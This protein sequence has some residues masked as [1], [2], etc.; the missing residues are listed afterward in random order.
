MLAAT[1][2]LVATLALLYLL[3]SVLFT[4][5]MSALIAYVLLPL[6]QLLV[7]WMPW[8]ESRPELS[9]SLAVTVIFVVA[10]GVT[11]GILAVVIPPTINQTEDFIDE[12]PTFFAAARETIEGWVGEYSD[13]VPQQLRAQIEDYIA[14]LSS[15]LAE[16]AFQILPK[17]VGFIAGSVSLIIGLAAM[18]VLI[19]YFT[20]DSKI[21][22]TYLISPLPKVLRPYLLDI[23][24]IADSTLG[25]YIR[26]QLILGLTVGVAVTI[27]L[28][29]LGIPFAAVLGVV[30]GI[31][32][33]VPIVGPWIGGAA[34]V[35]VALA[36][37]PEKIVWVAL[38]YLSVQIVENVLLVPRV[39]AHT[40]N[41][42]PAAV[43]IVIILGS[44]FFGFWG[45][46][47]GPPLLSLS[48]DIVK[49]LANEWHQ[50]PDAFDPP[51]ERPSDEPGGQN[52]N[53]EIT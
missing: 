2:F 46:I 48:K 10:T 37:A 23:A 53:S 7:S 50:L 20:K 11:A 41:I 13:R 29:A 24:R 30:A 12:F 49:Y 27:G 51:Q 52:Q 33:L 8:R 14:S 45:I 43:I 32:E 38:L 3:G 15:V 39:Q 18:P 6:A 5:L 21:I 25:G 35:L 40:L 36:T 31:S 9:R 22:G 4:V 28:M 47:L 16:S 44:H 42:H 26:G 19:F 34:G 1:A 17:T